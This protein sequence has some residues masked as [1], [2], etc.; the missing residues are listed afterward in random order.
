MSG[1]YRKPYWIVELDFGE[2]L[3]SGF[4]LQDRNKI[5][6]YVAIGEN[7]YNTRRAAAKR[8][9]EKLEGENINIILPV[10]LE[11]VP[12]IPPAA[13]ESESSQNPRVEPSVDTSQ[14]DVEMLE[15]PQVTDV[16][17]KLPD[18]ENTL[19][20]RKIGSFNEG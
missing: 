20:D 11:T 17:T 10:S 1:I 5:I 3:D 15:I 8:L 12:D 16:T 9:L 7:K 6:A 2:P 14:S 13:I 19:R 4:D 18:L